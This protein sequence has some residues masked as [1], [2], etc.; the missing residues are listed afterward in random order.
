MA[1]TLKRPAPPKLSL[2][3]AT[4]G[5]LM[6]ENPVSLRREASVREAAALMINRGF[7]VAPVVDD[8]GRAVGVVS[9]SDILIH[10]REN[11]SAVPPDDEGMF[12][13]LR[14]YSGFVRGA[15]GTDA[16]DP[17]TVDAIMTPAVLAVRRDTPAAEVVRKIVAHRVHHLFVADDDGTVVGVIGVSDIVRNLV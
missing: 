4:A 12:A 9:V 8:S 3:A 6:V 2:R 10:N 1:K 5:E 7:S 16:N 13:E 17:T 15:E 14:R 11:R